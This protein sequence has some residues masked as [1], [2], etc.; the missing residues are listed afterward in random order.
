MRMKLM[1]YTQQFIY[2]EKTK[3]LPTCLI[4]ETNETV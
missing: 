1:D 3:V 4:E 2:D